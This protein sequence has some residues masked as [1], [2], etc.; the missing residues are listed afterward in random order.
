MPNQSRFVIVLKKKMRRKKARE[1][2]KHRMSKKY[3]E[4]NKIYNDMLTNAKKRFY[5]DKVSKL[6][7]VNP[8]SWYRQLKSITKMTKCNDTPEVEDIKGHTAEEQAEMIAESFAK[9]SKEYEPASGQICIQ[10][11]STKRGGCPSSQ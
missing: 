8:K 2:T 3:I 1:Y 4:L 5:K 11:S 6:R 9:I 10:A 7:N